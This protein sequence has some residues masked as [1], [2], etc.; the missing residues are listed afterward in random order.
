MQPSQ[1]ITGAQ[2]ANYLFVQYSY[3]QV[4]DFLTTIAF[5]MNGVREGNPIV[6]AAIHWSP[7]P[8]AGLLAIKLAA[9][10][11]GVFCWR[12]GRQR[13]LFRVNV[14]FAAVV[15]WNVL[16]LILGSAAQ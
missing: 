1:G 7:N 16:A 3:L 13:M 8:L 11:L 4:L 9:V 14:L 6:R 15:A 2:S 12:M 10:A 5:L